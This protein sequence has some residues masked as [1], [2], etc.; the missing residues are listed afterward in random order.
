MKNSPTVPTSRTKIVAAFW[1]RYHAL[2]TANTAARESLVAVRDEIDRGF[3]NDAEAMEYEES[4]AYLVREYN[5]GLEQ[6]RALFAE[7]NKAGR[8]IRAAFD[9]RQLE[10][11]RGWV[12]SFDR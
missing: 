11:S 3:T 2:R 5:N 4:E 1:A 7:M 12:A 9:A 10:N 6:I 8:D